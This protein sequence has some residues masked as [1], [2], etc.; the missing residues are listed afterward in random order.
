METRQDRL[1]N[2]VG[3]FIF[4]LWLVVTVIM[5]ASQWAMVAWRCW[6]GGC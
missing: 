3:W 2:K 5:L 6:N 1:A 4:K